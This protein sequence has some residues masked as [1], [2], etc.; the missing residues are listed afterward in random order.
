MTGFQPE[1]TVTVGAG[2]LTPDDV[3]AVAR[4]GARIELAAESLAAI[5][6]GR[7]IVDALA[8]DAEPHYGVS[9]GF[10]ALAT[11]HIPVEL[12]TALQASL[13]RSHAAGSGAEVEDEVVRALMLL[14]LA[15]LA[16]GLTGVREETVQ[17]YVAV[18]NAGITPVVHEYGSL[19]CSGDLAPLA[20]CAL[21]IMGE[22][23]VRDAKGSHRP[24]AEA[25][26]EAGLEPV[27]LR[28]KEGLALIN[29]TDGML[30]MLVMAIADL[31]ALLKVADITASMSVE[32]LLGSDAPFAADLQALRPASRP[33][34]GCGE[35]AG[36][37][38]RQRDHG[39]PPGSGVYA[40]AGRVL[41][42]LRS[43]GRRG[44]A[45]YGRPRGPGG[46]PR[47]GCSHRQPRD[48]ARRPG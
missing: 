3:L 16:S 23:V 43:A 26:A 6:H 24:A 7:E 20:H 30:G 8:D 32:G 13:I 34:D 5:R 11:R 25:L 22:G 35:H 10:G 45:G 28:E 37:A 12:R 1:K 47:A 39:Q 15:T 40:S 44:S 9:T 17:A 33:G 46:E 19:G 31:R 42:A 18:L 27:E 2:P 38:G 36:D 14:R 21:V 41:A 48:H 4:D 29:G